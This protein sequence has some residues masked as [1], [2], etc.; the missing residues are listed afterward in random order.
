[1]GSTTSAI[2]LDSDGRER[3]LPALLFAD[4][5]VLFADDAVLFAND[6]VLFVD[7][8]VLFGESGGAIPDAD[9]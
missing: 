1:M 9:E 8:A 6:A 2:T 5:A 7:D 3:K 4:D